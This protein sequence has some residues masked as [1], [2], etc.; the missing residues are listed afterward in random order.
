VFENQ[1]YKQ[2]AS[3]KATIFE[4]VCQTHETEE[5]EEEE[6]DEGGGN[7]EQTRSRND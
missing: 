3:T 6:E 1:T 5:E 7:E 2:H 4:H